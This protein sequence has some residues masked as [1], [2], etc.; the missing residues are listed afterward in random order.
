MPPRP[1]SNPYPSLQD[2]NADTL[3]HLIGIGTQTGTMPGLRAVARLARVSK[4]L[5]ATVSEAKLLPPIRLL[6]AQTRLT[7]SPAAQTA[8]EHQLPECVARLAPA[9]QI[10][11]F[12]KLIDEFDRVP[13]G[14]ARSLRFAAL[15]R[16]ATALPPASAAAALARLAA[17]VRLLPQSRHHNDRSAEFA[18]LLDQC[19]LLTVSRTDAVCALARVLPLLANSTGARASATGALHACARTMAP[20]GAARLLHALIGPIAS[21]ARFDVRDRL[22]DATFATL[23]DGMPAHQ[24][25]AVLQEMARHLTLLTRPDDRRLSLR[26]HERSS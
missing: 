6:L 10:V 14:P 13:A 2:L 4:Q 8:F 12:T 11:L 23:D 1:G 7:L 19:R 15:R 18:A 22:V 24:E 5:R 26:R 20:P 17:C 16:T 9:A 25:S 3:S 21:L